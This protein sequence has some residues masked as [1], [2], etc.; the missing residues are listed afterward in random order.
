MTFKTSENRTPSMVNMKSEI[1]Y[2][3]PKRMKKRRE[4]DAL[5][6]TVKLPR[7]RKNSSSAQELLDYH[8]DSSDI[9]EYTTHGAKRKK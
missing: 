1:E 6:D 2:K 5:V 3:L 4:L 9:D 8:S 7:S